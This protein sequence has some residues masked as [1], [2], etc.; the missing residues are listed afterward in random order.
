MRMSDAVCDFP[1][2]LL[3]SVDCERVFAP[4]TDHDAKLA[5]YVR[6]LVGGQLR[7]D[8]FVGILR[9]G[10]TASV[11]RLPLPPGEWKGTPIPAAAAGSVEITVQG[12][13]GTADV[14]VTVPGAVPVELEAIR[15]LRTSAR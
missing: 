10:M 5:R 9:P 1:A 12:A 3:G 14:L 11:T 7:H 13:N 6:G 2:Y 15:L 4:G 8:R